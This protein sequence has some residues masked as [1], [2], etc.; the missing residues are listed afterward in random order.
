MPCK[1]PQVGRLHGLILP[2][3]ESS[4]AQTLRAVTRRD[5]TSLGGVMDNI[6]NLEISPGTITIQPCQSCGNNAYTFDTVALN[7]TGVAWAGT[8]RRCVNCE[9]NNHD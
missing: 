4:R 6:A 3:H 2:V 7:N 1:L 8:I 5:N 9:E